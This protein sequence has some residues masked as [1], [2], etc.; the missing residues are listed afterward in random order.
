M[1]ISI[2]GAGSIGLLFASYIADFFEV[3][4]YSKTEEQAKLIEEH[5]IVLIKGNDKKSVQVKALPF[6]KY[7]RDEDLTIL[8]VKQYQLT[9]VLPAVNGGN[10]FFL[11]NGMG[12]LETLQKLSSENIYVGS[13]EHGALKENEWTVRH[14]GEGITKSAIFRGSSEALISLSNTLSGFFPISLEV[15]YYEMLL[16]KLVAN[17]VINPLTAVLGVPNGRLLDN[18]Y[19]HMVFKQMFEEIAHILKLKNKEEMLKSVIE[20]CQ[21]T[22]KNR[23]SMLKDVEAHRKTEIDAILGYVVMEAEK[24]NIKAP[25]TENF[26]HMLKGKEKNRE[27]KS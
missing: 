6:E 12:H 24:Q 16:K 3:T 8:A 25:L 5:G 26:Y 15:D 2:I 13:V 7:M 21:K 23:S 27:G 1:K 17:A 11:Q 10:L 18:P 9:E 4:V 20:I 14:N 22:A 19:Y